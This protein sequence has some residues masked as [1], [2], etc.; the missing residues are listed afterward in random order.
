MDTGHWPSEIHNPQSHII[1]IFKSTFCSV[2]EIESDIKLAHGSLRSFMRPICTMTM[3]ND[4][5]ETK[6]IRS[7]SV[8]AQIK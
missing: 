8:T 6:S 1:I 3:R 2:I 4:E 5:I 7:D